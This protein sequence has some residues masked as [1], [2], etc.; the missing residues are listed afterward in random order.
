MWSDGNDGLPRD[1]KLAHQIFQQALI[2]GLKPGVQKM[3]K[4]VALL[5]YMPWE[6]WVEQLVHHHHFE[7]EKLE[8]KSDEYEKLRIDTIHEDE[9]QRTSRPE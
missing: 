6:Q 2:Q 3:L 1:S 5:D 7:Q 8:E 4:L 9:D